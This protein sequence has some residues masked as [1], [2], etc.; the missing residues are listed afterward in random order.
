MTEKQE[1]FSI[2][3]DTVTYGMD[4]LKGLGFDKLYQMKQNYKDANKKTKLALIV[5]S[6]FLVFNL[7]ADYIL[8][9]SIGPSDGL[10]GVVEGAMAITIEEIARKAIGNSKK[11]KQLDQALV[12][13]SGTMGN[14][15][16][17]STKKEL[18]KKGHFQETRIGDQSTYQ[19][20]LV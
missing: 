14:A 13:I 2:E 12:M 9:G 5:P 15:E 7:V 11:I 19:P 16:F 17:D 18:V 20:V 6:A 3:I 8:R 1:P 4:S 10:T